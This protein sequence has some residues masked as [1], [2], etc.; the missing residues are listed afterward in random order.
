[1]DDAYDSDQGAHGN[2]GNDDEEEEGVSSS[3]VDALVLIPPEVTQ[4]VFMILVLGAS[5]WAIV[6][7]AMYVFSMCMCHRLTHTYIHVSVLCLFVLCKKLA[8]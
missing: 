4:E 3:V 2:G 8:C 7:E 5:W 1:M 6:V